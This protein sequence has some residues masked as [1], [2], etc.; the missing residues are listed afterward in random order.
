MEKG[1]PSNFV[2][3]LGVGLGAGVFIGMLLAAKSGRERSDAI[4]ENPNRLWKEIVR[5]TRALVATHNKAFGKNIFVNPPQEDTASSRIEVHRPVFP[6]AKLTLWR[7]SAYVFS[8]SIERAESSFA[9][10][11]YSKGRME[12]MPDNK[13]NL[14][15]VF[16]DGTRLPTPQAVAE[17]LLEPIFFG[18]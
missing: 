9:H 17:H 2:V 10:S 12:V 1:V 11:K 6:I 18:I 16:E 14:Y 13:R 8:F 3:G 15:V 5:W 4:R 7:K